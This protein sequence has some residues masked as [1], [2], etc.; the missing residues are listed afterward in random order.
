MKPLHAD[1]EPLHSDF[2]RNSN[3]VQVLLVVSPT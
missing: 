3:R 2:L 1:H